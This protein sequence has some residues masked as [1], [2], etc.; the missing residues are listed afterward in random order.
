MVMVCVCWK[1]SDCNWKWGLYLYIFF[2]FRGGMGLGAGWGVW[3][4]GGEHHCCHCCVPH[5]SWPSMWSQSSLKPLASLQCTST[6]A[7][8]SACLLRNCSGPSTPWVFP[9]LQVAPLIVVSC[10]TSSRAKVSHHKQCCCLGGGGGE[11]QP[12]PPK[13]SWFYLIHWEQ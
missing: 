1:I 2:F 4:V 8:L 11:Q 7:Q 9:A 10:W 5:R 3:G 6:T 12:K 13:I